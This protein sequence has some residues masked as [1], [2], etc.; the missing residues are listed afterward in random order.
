MTS[1]V[2][3]LTLVGDRQDHFDRLVAGLA[4]STVQPGELVVSDIGE[5]PVR[6]PAAPFPIRRIAVAGSPPRLAA[7][8][9]RTAEAAYGR[10]LL[11]LDVDCIPGRHFVERL[12]AAI[13]TTDGLFCSEVFYLPQGAVSDGWSEHDLA[14]AGRAHPVRRF[15]SAGMRREDNPGLFWSLAFGVMRSAFERIGGFDER[16]VGYGAEDTDFGFAARKNGV[17]LFMLAG[18][19]AFHQHHR[20]FDPPL[21]HFDAILRNAERFHTKWDVW[22]MSGWLDAFA[23]LGLIDR[24]ATGPIVVRRQPTA[25][26]ISTAARPPGEPF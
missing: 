14:T 26:E 17:P 15:P 8:R 9:N 21:Q 10:R 24:P 7:A 20:T 25:D 2:S 23:D 18:A 19:P 5:T 6:L 22:P 3:V 16:F 1:D 4:R 13:E 11:F 12:S